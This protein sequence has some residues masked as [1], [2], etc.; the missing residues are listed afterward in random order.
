MNLHFISNEIIEIESDRATS[1]CCLNA[2]MGR[3]MKAGLPVFLTSAGHDQDQLARTEAGW[4][5]RERGCDMTSQV[6]HGES[7]SLQPGV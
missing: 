3:K 5:I 4:R 2:P 6:F 1:T 7:P